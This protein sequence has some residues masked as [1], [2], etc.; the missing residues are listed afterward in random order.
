MRV[1]IIAAQKS[2]VISGYNTDAGLIR[3]AQTCL[4][5]FFL[6]LTPRADEFDIVAIAKYGTPVGRQIARPIFVTV[7]KCTAD[8]AVHA[9]RQCD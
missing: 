9:A 2:H 4:H 1:V 8:I 3:Q 7:D 6:G 5:T